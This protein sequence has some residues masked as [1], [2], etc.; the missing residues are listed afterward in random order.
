MA[1]DASRP[2]GPQGVRVVDAVTTRER[3]HDKAQELVARVGPAR[4]LPEV[5]VLLDELL[6][7]EVRSER[8]RQEEPR[9]GHQAVVV[10]GRGEP[11]ETVG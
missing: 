9:V 2:A 7:A 10:K 4:R 1:K 6:E 11:I 3:R 8:G 5:E